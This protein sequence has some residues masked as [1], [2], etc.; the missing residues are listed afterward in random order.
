MLSAGGGKGIYFDL[1]S[2]VGSINELS[3]ESSEG[4]DSSLISLIY[5][6]F[7]SPNSFSYS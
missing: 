6:Y 1:G 3:T 4:D 2:V 7:S 5:S